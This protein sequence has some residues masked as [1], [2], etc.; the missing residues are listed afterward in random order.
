MIPELM[1][2]SEEGREKEAISAM[3]VVVGGRNEMGRSQALP[4]EDWYIFPANG[5][6]SRAIS[7]EETLA[8]MSRTF[9]KLGQQFDSK[10]VE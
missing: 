6:I 7:V 8:P 5:K 10:W 9:Y 4:R 3:R 1:V 2:E